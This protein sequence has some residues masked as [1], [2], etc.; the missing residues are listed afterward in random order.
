MAKNVDLDSFGGKPDNTI[1]WICK[2]PKLTNTKGT[3]F[4]VACDFPDNHPDSE[5]FRI[6]AR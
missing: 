5:I 1:C 4:C 2:R 6:I 3:H